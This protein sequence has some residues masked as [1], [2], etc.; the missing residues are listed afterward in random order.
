MVEASP[1]KQAPE[2]VNG[3]DDDDDAASEASSSG[4]PPPLIQGSEYE[5]FVCGSCV[6]GIHTL[7]RYAGTPG[8]LMVVRDDQSIDWKIIGDTSTPHGD[9]QVEVSDPTV[10]MNAGTKRPR[11][12]SATA[13]TNSPE[14]KR[15][16]A[17]SGSTAPCLGPSPSMIASRIFT[18]RAANDVSLG[19]GDIFL[20]EGWRDRWCHCGSV[21]LTTLICLFVFFLNIHLVQVSSFYRISTV[22]SARRRNV[23]ASRGP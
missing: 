6:S 9:S 4:L 20:T 13:D 16:R 17:S 23:R 21:S 5:S 1:T 11:S 10:T 8:I 15:V 3:A 14:S 18:S 7:K 22:S 19:A 12:P 2:E